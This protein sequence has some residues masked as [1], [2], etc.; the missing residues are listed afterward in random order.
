[1]TVYSKGK[2]EEQVQTEMA[3]T[4]QDVFDTGSLASLVPGVEGV[5][6]RS[7]LP[8]TQS[9]TSPDFLSLDGSKPIASG[10]TVPPLS[11]APVATLVTPTSV[12][13]APPPTVAAVITE[14]SA[15]TESPL[16]D[17]KSEDSGL[18]WWRW[19]LVAVIIL[20]MIGAVV[21]VWFRKP[22]Q[23]QSVPPDDDLSFRDEQNNDE[24]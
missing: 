2:S 7:A 22:K 21:F 1:M 4:L 11:P 12:P 5:F 18:D 19:M 24:F 16:E 14:Q 8:S 23:A 6:F 10:Q 9:P 13:S 15:E 20:V 17:S 3:Q